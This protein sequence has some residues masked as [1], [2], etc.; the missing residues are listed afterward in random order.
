[1]KHLLL[2]QRPKNTSPPIQKP[3][4]V[5]ESD[6]TFASTWP[7]LR[8][9]KSDK[10]SPS[11]RPSP[12]G[13]GRIVVRHLAIRRVHVTKPATRRWRGDGSKQ[14]DKRCSLSPGER[15]RV[16]ASQKLCSSFQ[17]SFCTSEDSPHPGL[18]LKDTQERENLWQ[19][20]ES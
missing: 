2:S 3:R 4:Q 10:G 11:P 1:M 14:I 5:L 9:W 19:Q 20:L 16:R 15:V 17:S 13:R 6:G 7:L 18:L 12:P 8:K